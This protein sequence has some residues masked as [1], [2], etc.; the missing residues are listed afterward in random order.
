MDGNRHAKELGAALFTATGTSATITALGLSG[1]YVQ[2]NTTVAPLA[3]LNRGR[4]AAVWASG[5][6][7]GDD[8]VAGLVGPNFGTVVASYSTASRNVGC[9][10]HEFQCESESHVPRPPT[11]KTSVQTAFSRTSE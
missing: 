2:G 1:A 11:H 8:V 5:Q 3:G 10:A 4:V 6:V 9:G 7:V